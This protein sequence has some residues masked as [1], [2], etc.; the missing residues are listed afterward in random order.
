MGP[1]NG[2][3]D[4]SWFLLLVN[5]VHE[6]GAPGRL[7]R[8]VDPNGVR[9]IDIPASKRDQNG[10]KSLIKIAKAGWDRATKC[11]RSLY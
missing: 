11:N 8:C 3:G 2:I 10:R 7:V 5:I 1:D 4:Q 6:V 9:Y